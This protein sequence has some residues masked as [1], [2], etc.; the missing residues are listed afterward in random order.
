MYIYTYHTVSIIPSWG[1][2][3]F[4][5]RNTN[6]PLVN[7]HLF[8]PIFHALFVNV[9][10]VFS[11]VYYIY[12][13]TWTWVYYDVVQIDRT[14]LKLFKYSY[15]GNNLRRVIRVVQILINVV[16]IFKDDEGRTVLSDRMFKSLEI[17]NARKIIENERR[18]WRRRNDDDGGGG[19]KEIKFRIVFI[20]KRK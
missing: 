10:C 13:C 18:R 14:D 1:G 16:R 5:Q 15:V 4:E 9:S 6:I 2:G 8:F 3:K 17:C 19:A 11:T 7:Y 12:I 20:F